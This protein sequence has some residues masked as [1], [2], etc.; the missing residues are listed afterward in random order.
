MYDLTRFTLADVVELGRALGRAESQPS[1]EEAAGE[2]VAHLCEHLQDK[3]EGE[4]ACLLGRMFKTVRLHRLPPRLQALARR[5]AGERDLAPETGCLTL[6]ATLGRRPEW[7]D[8][9]R[10]HHHQAIPLVGDDLAVRTPMVAALLDHLAYDR[11]PRSP[12]AFLAADEGDV[13][14]VLHVPDATLGGFCDPAFVA[15][16]GVRSVVA[17]GGPL[18]DGEVYAVV[19]FTSCPVDA[20][21]AELFRFAVLSTTGA[22]LPSLGRLFADDP[23]VRPDPGLARW[24][25]AVLHRLLAV[26]EATVLEQ[27]ARLEETLLGLEA[28]ASELEAARAAAE[29]S[30]ARTAA[31][32]EASLDAILTM[33][34]EGRVV[35]LN[36]AAEEL[37][38]WPRH[39][40]LGSA[41]ADRL[42]P[43]H[44][45]ERHRQALAEH[46]ATGATRI[47]GRRVEVPALGRDGEELPVELTVTRVPGAGPPLFTGFVRDLRTLRR[48]EAE[49]R[50]LVASVE[51]S[52]RPP[53]PPEVAGLEVASRYLSAAR[54]LQIGGDFLDVFQS[55]PGR[56]LVVLGDVC[57]KGAAAA[58]RSSLSRHI[59]RAASVRSGVPSVLVGE[60]NAVLAAE[61]DPDGGALCS[62]VVA[63]FEP[64][65]GTGGWGVQTCSAGHPLPV[66]VRAGGGA[67]LVGEPGLLLGLYPEIALGDHDL[68]LA[69]GDAL[70]LYTDGIHEARNGGGELFGQERLVAVLDEAR[71]GP[72]EAMADAVMEAVAGFA[73]ATTD[74][75]ALVVLRVPPA[76]QAPPPSPLYSPPR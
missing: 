61:D 73:G 44:L 33:D 42:V 72:A 12:E 76:V 1:T 56:W 18:P 30:E 13:L 22:L 15:A 66:V 43:V 54:G 7:N 25:A 71:A 21:T 24:Q 57:G 67:G 51:A 40:A 38:A 47:L 75:V 45:R 68:V 49:L 52:L 58:A 70:A 28:R 17:F 6:L 55:D 35:E 4:R 14:D 10:S 23:P 60:L 11:R 69:P 53:R 62:V 59:L 9:R 36:P 19:L 39:E 50:V 65:P 32:L 2:I 20:S 37:F 5:E 3:V 64:T 8:R 74:D 16:E 31:I 26:R 27:T 41:L 29:A 63:G 46:L 48:T 34:A